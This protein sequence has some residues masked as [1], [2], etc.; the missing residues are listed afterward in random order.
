MQ[1][2]INST[3]LESVL[4]FDFFKFKNSNLAVQYKEIFGP[5]TSKD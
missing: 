1:R 2:F 3:F 4:C 5:T